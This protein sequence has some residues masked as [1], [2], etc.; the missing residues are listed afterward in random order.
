MMPA[1]M[2]T[3][4]A[5]FEQAFL[6]MIPMHHQNASDMAALAPGRAAR[7]ELLQLARNIVSTRGQEIIQMRGWAQ[8][9]YGFDPM[10]MRMGGGMSGLPNTGGGGMARS[11]AG[12]VPTALI[13]LGALMLAERWLLRRRITPR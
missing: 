12:S 3:T 4:G 7:P 5:E 10:P 11:T 6:T 13:A 2:Q 8:A 1:M 9:W